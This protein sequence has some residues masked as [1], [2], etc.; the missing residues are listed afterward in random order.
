MHTTNAANGKNLRGNLLSAADAAEPSTAVKSARKV[1]GLSIVLGV[2]L[3]H[4]KY[5]CLLASPFF[6][7]ISFDL[8][9]PA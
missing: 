3:L 5:C 6:Y 2:W 1:L 4:S 7:H 8:E 9:F